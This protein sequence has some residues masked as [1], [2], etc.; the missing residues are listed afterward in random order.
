MLA[1]YRLSFPGAGGVLGSSISRIPALP[2]SA[3]SQ[4]AVPGAGGSASAGGR[5]G[6]S[7]GTGMVGVGCR[8]RLL[9]RIWGKASAGRSYPAVAA[10]AAPASQCQPGSPQ[11]KA[12]QS[13]PS[14]SSLEFFPPIPVIWGGWTRRRF[15]E[16]GRIQRCT[17]T[18]GGSSPTPLFF[19]F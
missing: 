5:G 15:E 13:A 11:E 17:G 16:R 18:R 1:F 9:F 12:M 2:G 7:G 6:T 19:F 10:P 8:G 3:G 14:S 4:P